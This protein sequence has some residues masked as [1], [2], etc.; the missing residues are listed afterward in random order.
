MMMYPLGQRLLS[1]MRLQL[2]LIF[3]SL[4]YPELVERQLVS[5]CTRHLSYILVMPRFGHWVCQRS[6]AWRKVYCT[7]PRQ[8]WDQPTCK[9][10][11]TRISIGGVWVSES[12][13]T[14]LMWWCCACLS[15]YMFVCLFVCLLLIFVLQKKITEKSVT[16]SWWISWISTTTIQICA[17]TI[18]YIRLFICFCLALFCFVF[19]L[20]LFCLFICLFLF[21]LVV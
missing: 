10:W 15:I 5:F 19:I 2:S 12:T 8:A 11:C 13:T 17:P 21:G 4:P 14:R 1:T 3:G 20:R 18:S 7:W 6:S 16:G 9:V